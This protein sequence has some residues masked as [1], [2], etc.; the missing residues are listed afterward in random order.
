MM[1]FSLFA[2][3]LLYMKPQILCYMVKF[4]I[5]LHLGGL[6]PSQFQFRWGRTAYFQQQ[7]IFGFPLI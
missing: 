1:Q 6:A 3:E 7:V 5:Y 4:G 2:I